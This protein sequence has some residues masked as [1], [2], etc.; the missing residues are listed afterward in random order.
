MKRRREGKSPDPYRLGVIPQAT[1]LGILFRTTG[2]ADGGPD[3]S[4]QATEDGF[5]SPETSQSENCSFQGLMGWRNLDRFRDSIRNSDT[6][7]F[8]KQ[9]KDEEEDDCGNAKAD[10]ILQKSHYC[11]QHRRTVRAIE[12]HFRQSWTSKHS[13][14]ALGQQPAIMLK[15]RPI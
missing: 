7:R 9:Q 13:N 3:N 10:C 15:P 8:P 2:V 4:I 11:L 1:I 5:W 6:I 12:F 14:M